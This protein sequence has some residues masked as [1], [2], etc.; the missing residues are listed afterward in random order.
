MS[1]LT[2]SAPATKFW[3]DRGAA[4]WAR[5]LPT[6]WGATA[7]PHRAALI[8]R[9]RKLPAFESIRELG[10]C[11]GTNLAMIRQ[12]FPYVAIEGIELSSEATAFAQDKLGKDPLTRV[13]CQDILQCSYDWEPDEADVVF[14]CYTLAYVAPENIL[15]LLAS[16]LRSARKAVVLVEPMYG[17]IGRMPVHYT[18][19][20][21]HDYAALITEAMQF[22][23]R[24]AHFVA[25]K[26]DTPVEHCDGIAT[27]IFNP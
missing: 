1:S 16:I 2:A 23:S 25:E 4:E 21:R 22:D 24:P 18:C 5:V 20:W 19:E 27:V 8:N 26:L 6:Y 3:R 13:I 9:L 10:C 11:A 14:T 15:A 7:Q 12:Q 17:P